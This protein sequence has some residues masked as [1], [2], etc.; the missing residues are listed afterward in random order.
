[1]HW[2]LSFQS[3]GQA[4][5]KQ[6]QELA[7]QIEQTHLELKT[8][9][10]LQEHESLA[11]PKRVEALTEDVNRQVEREKALQKR[12]DDLLQQKELIEEALL[13]IRA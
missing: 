2:I 8:F 13:D 9:R 6:I 4:L 5:I 10:A 7:E 11:I 3:R 1:M 12:Y